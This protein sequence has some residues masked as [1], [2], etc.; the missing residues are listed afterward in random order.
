MIVCVTLNPCLDKTLCVGPWRPGDHV[1][2]RSVR[3]VVGGKGNNVARALTRLGHV[4]RPATILGGDIGRRCERLLRG[5]D[6]LDPIVA[7]SAAETRVILTVRAVDGAEPTA[8]FDPD[9]AVTAE[10]AAALL[11][12]VEGTLAVGGV[13]ALTLS[14]SSPSPATHDIYADMIALARSRGVPTF[15]D[16]YGPPLKH[17]W[18]FWPEVIQLNRR[19]AAGHLGVDDPSDA[20]VF[21][22]LGEWSRRGV[23]LAVVTDG[24]GPV[25]AA[26]RGRRLV[27]RPPAIEAVNPVG[28]GDSMLAG[29]VD[30]RLSGLDGAGMLRRG[31]AAAAANALAWDAGAVDPGLVASL[32]AGVAV[33]AFADGEPS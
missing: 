19:E 10:E 31:I 9:P 22:L 15:L 17:L 14:G 28:S 23:E 11:N 12:M 4:A 13:E 24:P 2:G 3:E 30:G 7:P 26:S 21:G 33:R 8:F 1:R 29:L 32:E 25:L 16:T 6:G 5:D 20:E 18:G 27:A